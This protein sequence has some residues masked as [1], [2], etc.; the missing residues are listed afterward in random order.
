MPWNMPLLLLSQQQHLICRYK[1]VYINP[2]VTFSAKAYETWPAR[3]YWHHLCQCSEQQ[4][5]SPG[6]VSQTCAEEHV[7]PS[8]S[9]P[10]ARSG[11]RAPGHIRLA[12]G[13][14]AWSSGCRHAGRSCGTRKSCS[15]QSSASKSRGSAAGQLCLSGF[16]QLVSKWSCH[17]LLWQKDCV[18]N[19][20]QMSFSLFT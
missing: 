13:T 20:D 3:S 14:A 6:S 2:P 16:R 12:F 9:L 17:L 8:S 1:P 18:R 7:P 11:S 4:P 5:H 10:G 15:G 19:S